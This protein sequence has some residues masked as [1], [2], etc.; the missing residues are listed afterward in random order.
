MPDEKNISAASL[1]DPEYLDKMWNAAP[2]LPPPGE[3][4]ACK[5][6]DEIR[7]LRTAL[8]LIAEGFQTPEELHGDPN[9]DALGFEEVISMAYENIQL[10]A[11]QA[12][13]GE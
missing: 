2:L 6:I 9:V 4:V 13:T 3:E 1:K 7:A 8:T 10:A 11:K 5:L 12:L